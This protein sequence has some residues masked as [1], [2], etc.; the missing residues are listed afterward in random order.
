MSAANAEQFYQRR[1]KDEARGHQGQAK[2]FTNLSNSS[3]IFHPAD[4]SK[5]AKVYKFLFEP[6]SRCG[7]R[8][9]KLCEKARETG[10]LAFRTSSDHW[11][12]L[13]KQENNDFVFLNVIG[14]K[15]HTKFF[16][17]N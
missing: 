17:L 3:I 12:F 9:L 5:G 4:S 10:Q 13:S 7:C 14:Q 1:A 11:M 16:D 15:L 8:L 6:L 2:S